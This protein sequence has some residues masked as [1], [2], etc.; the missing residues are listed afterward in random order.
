LEG[1]TELSLAVVGSGAA[2]TEMAFGLKA[3]F[4]YVHAEWSWE[5]RSKLHTSLVLSETCAQRV[6][7]QELQL[8]P[9]MLLIDSHDKPLPQGSVYLVSSLSSESSPLSPP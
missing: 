7:R 9:E 4:K 5:T 2:G 1:R 8:D 3:R 6:A